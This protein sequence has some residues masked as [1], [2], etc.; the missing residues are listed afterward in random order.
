MDLGDGPVHTPGRSHLAPVQ[1]EALHW[2]GYTTACFVNF[3]H[4]RNLRHKR[5]AVNGLRPA[6]HATLLCQARRPASVSPGCRHP[7]C[8][9]APRYAAGWSPKRLAAVLF[10]PSAC[11]LCS[12]GTIDRRRRM[13]TRCLPQSGDC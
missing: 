7:R 8:P 12:A 1:N 5:T 13:W 3:C 9:D 4:D 2:T 11:V 6:L 10:A